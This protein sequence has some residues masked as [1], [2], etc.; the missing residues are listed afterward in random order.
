MWIKLAWREVGILEILVGEVESNKRLT[1]CY[2]KDLV[3][4]L[5][6]ISCWIEGHGVAGSMSTL[7]LKTDPGDYSNE[8]TSLK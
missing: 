1:S 5:R 7:V 6:D 8:G 4:E 3:R 2:D